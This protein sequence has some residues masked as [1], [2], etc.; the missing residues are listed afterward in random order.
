MKDELAAEKKENEELDTTLQILEKQN[1]LFRKQKEDLEKTIQ[2]MK[3]EHHYEIQRLKDSKY[4]ETR[5]VEE[6]KNSLTLRVQSL[7]VTLRTVM[8]QGEETKRHI[9]DLDNEILEVRQNNEQLMQ[10]IV[11][12][13]KIASE[14]IATKQASLEEK[15]KNIKELEDSLY[16]VQQKAYGLEQNLKEEK[17]AKVMEERRLLEAKD[18]KE[19]TELQSKKMERELAR[20]KGQLEESDSKCMDLQRKVRELERELKRKTFGQ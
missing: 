20:V 8:Q 3:I 15:E 18:V 1:E 2:T 4:E 6:E 12:N 16:E 9:F 11:E 5:S 17:N 13:E 14:A 19:I 10:K 7:E